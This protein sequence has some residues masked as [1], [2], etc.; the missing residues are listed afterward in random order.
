MTLVFILITAN[1]ITA[2]ILIETI[3]THKPIPAGEV[4]HEVPDNA[5]PMM[6]GYLYDVLSIRDYGVNWLSAELVDLLRRRFI[7]LKKNAD[8]ELSLLLLRPDYQNVEDLYPY[9]KKIIESLFPSSSSDVFPVAYGVTQN[10]QT[11]C[12]FAYLK[13]AR[14]FLY[15][16]YKILS[17]WRNDLLAKGYIHN[18]AEVKKVSGYNY[19]PLSAVISVLILVLGMFALMRVFMLVQTANYWTAAMII[20]FFVLFAYLQGKV[21]AFSRFKHPMHAKVAGFK[22]YLQKVEAPRLLFSLKEKKLE[23]LYSYVVLF[24]VGSS[25]DYKNLDYA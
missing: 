11:E 10:D 17:V 2:I 1:I 4:S 7:G 25:N 12:S 16:Q 6:L 18:M 22:E 24:G 14:P 9:Q 21:N 20:G 5:P 19:G 15:N 3:V 13:Y 23:K 8:G